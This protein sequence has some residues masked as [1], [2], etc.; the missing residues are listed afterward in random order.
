[1][2]RMFVVVVC[3]LFSYVHSEICGNVDPYCDCTESSN[4][5]FV[6]DCT[7][8]NFSLIPTFALSIEVRTNI[9][10]FSENN[11]ITVNKND[12]TPQ[13]W[14]QLDTIDFRGN[15][16]VNCTSIQLM[17]DSFVEFR[18]IDAN[19]LNLTVYAPQHCT[20]LPIFTK[21]VSTMETQTPV[22][23]NTGSLQN[24]S[25]I[26][27]ETR[28]L[29]ESTPILNTNATTVDFLPRSTAVPSPGSNAIPIILTSVGLI[30]FLTIIILVVIVCKR[31]LQLTDNNRVGVAHSPIYL[32]MSEFLDKN[33]RN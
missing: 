19:P 17:I 30:I 27:T 21:T 8:R 31:R 24:T 1:M 20:S 32:E 23:N 18:S 11:L 4:D 14:I 7:R 5:L 12:F 25:S 33:R 2:D 3:I 22:S 28:F 29:K 15:L 9:F 16:N 6:V 26:S 10:L 13:S